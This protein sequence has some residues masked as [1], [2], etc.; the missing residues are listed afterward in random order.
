MVLFYFFLCETKSF[1]A[2]TFRLLDIRRVKIIRSLN[3]AL[4]SICTEPN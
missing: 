3:G 1:H 4:L 2:S